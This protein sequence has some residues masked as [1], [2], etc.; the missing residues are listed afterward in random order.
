LGTVVVLY[1]DSFSHFHSHFIKNYL[2]E[3]IVNEQKVVI[4]DPDNY[5]DRQYWL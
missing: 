5:R 2:A 4:F 3:G 1:E